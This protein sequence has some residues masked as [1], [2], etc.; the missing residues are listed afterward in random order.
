MRRWTRKQQVVIHTAREIRGI[1]AAARATAVVLRDLCETVRPGMSTLDI[2]RLAGDLIRQTGG[3]SAFHGYRGFPAQICISVN[4]EVVHGIGRPDRTI[5]PGDLVSLDVG[6]CLDGYIGDTATTMCAGGA[7]CQTPLASRLVAI[8][9]EG[10][11]RGIDAAVPGHHV[12]DIGRAVEAAVAGAGFS[13]VRD[14]VGHG[15][16]VELHEP[17]EVPNFTTAKRGPRLQ[18]GMV[19]AIEP[20]INVGGSAI[21]VES[22]GW[23]VRTADGSL[24][25]HV[26]HMVLVTDGKPEKLTWRKTT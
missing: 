3:T 24:S 23:T 7:A 11:A 22:D 18:P 5:E 25:A 4:D 14:F 8:A 9:N 15:C 10:L 1:R 16:G 21:R 26:E 19:L 13:V 20:M 2:D 6:V 12:N 17:P